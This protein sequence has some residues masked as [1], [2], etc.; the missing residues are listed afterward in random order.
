MPESRGRIAFTPERRACAVQSAEG[1]SISAT[2]G[3]THA[4]SR[5][6]SFAL[7]VEQYD[8]RLKLRCVLRNRLSGMEASRKLEQ[9]SLFN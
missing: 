5:G 7:K 2:Q 3:K 8:I 6:G 9:R 1:S 4:D